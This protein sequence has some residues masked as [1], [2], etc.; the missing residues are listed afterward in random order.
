MG[1][2]APECYPT[3]PGILQKSEELFCSEGI[4]RNTNFGRVNKCCG[5]S[6]IGFAFF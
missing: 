5:I 1:S 3:P 6:E 4:R 2:D